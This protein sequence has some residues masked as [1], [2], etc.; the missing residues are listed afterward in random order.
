MLYGDQFPA[1]RQIE[2]AGTCRGIIVLRVAL[3]RLLRL[4]AKRFWSADQKLFGYSLRQAADCLFLCKEIH[5]ML[6]KNIV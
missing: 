6:K 2:L 5:I 1:G 3:I 4:H